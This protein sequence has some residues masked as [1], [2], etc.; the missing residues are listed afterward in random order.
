MSAT[1]LSYTTREQK[2]LDVFKR[3]VA[4][5]TPKLISSQRIFGAVVRRGYDARLIGM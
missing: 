4:A 1:A 5:F 2:V 3:H